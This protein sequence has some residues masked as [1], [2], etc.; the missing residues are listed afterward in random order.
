MSVWLKFDLAYVVFAGG[1]DV[2]LTIVQRKMQCVRHKR[3]QHASRK[4]NGC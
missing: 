4:V 1:V 3:Q 2:S